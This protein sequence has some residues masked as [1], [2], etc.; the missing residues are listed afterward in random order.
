MSYGLYGGA[1]VYNARFPD[2]AVLQMAIQVAQ[3]RDNRLNK[4]EARVYNDTLIELEYGFGFFQ[5]AHP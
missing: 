1:L 2:P 5:R 4:E 3:D